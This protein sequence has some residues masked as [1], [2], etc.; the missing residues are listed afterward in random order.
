[1]QFYAAQTHERVVGD[2]SA[3][4]HPQWLRVSAVEWD[5]YD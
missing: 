3:L 5:A 4:D 1:M 2:S